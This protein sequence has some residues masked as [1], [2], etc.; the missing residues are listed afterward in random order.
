[1]VA[2]MAGFALEDMFIKQVSARIPIGELLVIFGVIGAVVFAVLARS[3]NETLFSRDLLIAPVF[4]RSLGEV[5]G[6]FGFVTAIARIP[7][8]TAAAIL[9]AM[10][11]V[12]TLGAV[13]VFGA[14]VGLRRWTAITFGLIGV[15]LVIR[16]GLSGFDINS[17]FAVLAVIGLA[18]RD[19]ATRAVPT[20]IS[21]AQLSAYGFGVLVPTGLLISWIG[22]APVMP[23]PQ[24]YWKLAAM[25]VLG[26]A[27]YYAI[28]AAM[29]VGDVAVVTPFRYTRLLFALVIGLVV[30][31]E[32][33]DALTA[34]GAAIIIISGLYS[35]LRER[36]L[37][38]T[39]STDHGLS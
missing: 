7:L 20:N 18:I 17:L 15:L 19:L 37:P 21:S 3:Q 39:L 27:A 6:T 1:M 25:S 23:D 12:V 34:T 14:T 24:D 5:I 8:S 28:T 16:P 38:R 9:Q 31:D 29:R 22:V 32:H 36:N 26:L 2:A 33:L 10:P 30:F 4:W 13:F 11:L 35:Y